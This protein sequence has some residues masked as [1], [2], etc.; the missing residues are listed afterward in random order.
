[1]CYREEEKYEEK[2]DERKIEREKDLWEEEKSELATMRVRGL[3][4]EKAKGREKK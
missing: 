3:R 1:M 4:R 2:R